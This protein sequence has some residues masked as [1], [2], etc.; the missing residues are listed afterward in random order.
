MTADQASTYFDSRNWDKLTLAEGLAIKANEQQKNQNHN[1]VAYDSDPKKSNWSWLLGSRVGSGGCANVNWN[2][3]NH[4]FKVNWN[5]AG[6]R[7]PSLGARPA[8]VVPIFI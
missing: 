1:F 8:V 2:P 7:N 5:D 4:Q 6:N 3:N